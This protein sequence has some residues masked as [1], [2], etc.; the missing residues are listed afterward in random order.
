MHNRT[1]YRGRHKLDPLLWRLNYQANDADALA[2]GLLPAFTER[3]LAE[4]LA[5]GFLDAF[6]HVTSRPVDRLHLDAAA[7]HAWPGG[8]RNT[9]ADTSLNAIGA[10]AA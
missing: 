5:C 3:P 4:S 6:D 8:R 2:D 1:A 9:H 10:A 7:Q